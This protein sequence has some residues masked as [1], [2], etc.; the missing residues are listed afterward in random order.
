MSADDIRALKF[1]HME[2]KINFNHTLFYQFNLQS[3]VDITKNSVSNTLIIR[4]PF[5]AYKGKYTWF[6]DYL[7]QLGDRQITTTA[8]NYNCEVKEIPE[9][10]DTLYVYQSKRNPLLQRKLVVPSNIK[11]LDIYIRVAKFDDLTFPIGL[12][13]LYFRSSPSIINLAQPHFT[14]LTTLSISGQIF[15]GGACPLPP[16][17]T[18]LSM[19]HSN[20][21]SHLFDRLTSLVHVDLHLLS[22]RDSSRTLD[23]SKQV[24]LESFILKDCVNNQSLGDIHIHLSRTSLTRLSLPPRLISKQSTNLF[25]STLK[26]LTVSLETLTDFKVTSC[27][28]DTLCLSACSRSI[29]SDLIPNSVKTLKIVFTNINLG[30]SLSSSTNITS[31]D[32]TY[33]GNICGIISLLPPNLVHFSLGCERQLPSYFLVLP[34]LYPTS[35]E[36]LD[37][38]RVFGRYDKIVV[39]TT[40]STLSLNL[41]SMPI[42]T[43]F[44]Q[45]RFG[46]LPPS[47][48]KLEIMVSLADTRIRLDE[49]INKT[50]VQE[51]TLSYENLP[52]QNHISIR[53]L[54]DHNRNVLV[55]DNRTLNGG[56]IETID[57]DTNPIYLHLQ[58]FKYHQKLCWSNKI[59]QVD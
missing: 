27:C 35:L 45:L 32:V 4:D 54:D 52:L 36:T 18:N 50:N 26:H 23:L 3:F 20:F 41:C 42:G 30:W 38:S 29:T 58:C 40:I 16:N 10:T 6:L 8:Y 44:D 7:L 22:A 56:I 51:L 53:R 11:T 49:I 17:L 31:L 2:Y 43:I 9:S 57:I 39:P 37:Y 28:L 24:C 12:E 48:K 19:S 1:K 59:G 55:V 34:V 46:S 5:L 13:T 15:E 47:I 21:D 14:N 33:L 25:P